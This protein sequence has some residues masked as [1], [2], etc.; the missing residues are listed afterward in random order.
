MPCCS[1]RE[2]L[3][4]HVSNVGLILTKLQ[5]F[6]Y[7]STSK[8][9]LNFLWKKWKFL[10][11][12]L[13]YLVFIKYLVCP[14]V[15]GTDRQTRFWNPDMET[16]R[17]TKNFISKFKIRSYLSITIF[18]PQYSLFKQLIPWLQPKSRRVE[19]TREI[20]HQGV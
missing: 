16:C 2:D 6:Q 7:F 4:V 12:M 5:W 15:R 8:F 10:V 13:F 18:T 20:Y 14:S 19:Y 9:N 1:T 17:H 11:S 3:S